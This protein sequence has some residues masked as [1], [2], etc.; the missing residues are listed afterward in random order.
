MGAPEIRYRKQVVG[1]LR[2]LWKLLKSLMFATSS[3]NEIFSPLLSP[4][5]AC[6]AHMDFSTKLSLLCI[7]L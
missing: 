2:G 1:H 5:R 6:S 7:I 4:A 3:P